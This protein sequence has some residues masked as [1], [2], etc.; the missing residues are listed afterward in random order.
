[1]AAHSPKV[2]TKESK[3]SSSRQVYHSA[4]VLVDLNLDFGQFLPKSFGHSPW[5]PL[6][7][8]TAIHKD[9][10]II[11]IPRI[12]HVR[13]LAVASNLSGPLQHPIHLGEVDV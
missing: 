8:R 3:V 13:V 5:Q 6:M 1:M 2:K 10:Q 12:V 4:L 9:Y 11:S 7:M